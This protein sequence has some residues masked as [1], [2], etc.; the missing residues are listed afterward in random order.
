M[1][2]NSTPSTGFVEDMIICPV[3]VYSTLVIKTFDTSNVGHS[4]CHLI[5]S[6]FTVVSL[7][8]DAAAKPSI[9]TIRVAC[10][11]VRIGM[12]GSIISLDL[13]WWAQNDSVSLPV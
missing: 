10:S 5:S 13:P 3:Q 7:D 11:S 4:R 12:L 9:F 2:A 1:A 6:H 8:E